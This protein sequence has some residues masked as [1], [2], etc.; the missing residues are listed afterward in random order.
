MTAGYSL[1]D[2]AVNDLKDIWL[3]TKNRW[4][5]KKADEYVRNLYKQFELLVLNP[6]KG[7]ERLGFNDDYRSFPMDKHVIF[8]CLKESEIYVVRVLHQSMDVETHLH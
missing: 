1:S 6:K 4:G 2:N 8:Y 5:V 3:Y 7:R